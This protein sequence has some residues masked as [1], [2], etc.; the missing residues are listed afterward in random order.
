[1]GQSLGNRFFIEGGEEYSNLNELIVNHV[2]AIARC[3]EELMAHEK[4]KV[5]PEDKLCKS[6]TMPQLMQK[7]FKEQDTR[8]QNQG[9]VGILCKKIKKVCTKFSCDNSSYYK[10]TI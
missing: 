4:F 8:F 1:M 3:T 2:R 6:Y 5:G 9:K 7:T 10:D